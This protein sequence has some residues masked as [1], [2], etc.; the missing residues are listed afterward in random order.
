MFSLLVS[1]LLMV[2]WGVKQL[3]YLVN[4]KMKSSD[5]RRGLQVRSWMYFANPPIRR[6]D[7][8]MLPG[9][10]GGG[11]GLQLALGFGLGSDVCPIG[12]TL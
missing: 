12:V 5:S 4:E 11:R 10:H 8:M 2:T 7:R 3:Y 6:L 9:G 1:F